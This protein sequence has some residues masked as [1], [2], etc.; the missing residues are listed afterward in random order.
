MLVVRS[1][2]CSRRKPLLTKTRTRGSFHIPPPPQNLDDPQDFCENILWTD[3]TKVDLFGRFKS[4]YILNKTNKA[5]YEKNLILT[6]NQ[7]KNDKKFNAITGRPPISSQRLLSYVYSRVTEMPTL[8]SIHIWQVRC[9]T[10]CTDYLQQ[11]IC[12]LIIS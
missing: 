10:C 7:S 3:G 2:V 4:R 9:E 11:F 6:C 5:F 1:P 12:S 8:T